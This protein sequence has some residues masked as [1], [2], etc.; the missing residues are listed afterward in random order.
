[1][2]GKGL[3]D[4]TPALRGG[5]SAAP[6]ASGVVARTP[7][8][9][10]ARW[11]PVPA[12]CRGFAAPEISAESVPCTRGRQSERRDA[13]LADQ[14]VRGRSG[15][16]RRDTRRPLRCWPTA[17][18]RAS[19]QAPDCCSRARSRDADRRRRHRPATRQ[20]ARVMGSAAPPPARAQ[21]VEI[22]DTPEIG[23]ELRG[24]LEHGARGTRRHSPRRHGTAG[25]RATCELVTK[26]DRP[27]GRSSRF[28][29][30]AAAGRRERV[31]GTRI[32]PAAGCEQQD[33]E[34]RERRRAGD[35]KRLLLTP[36]RFGG[37]PR[38]CSARRA[39]STVARRQ[40]RFAAL[41]K[42]DVAAISCCSVLM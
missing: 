19:A 31:G 18:R 41:R 21:L 1:M 42:H 36:G 11:R 30:P 16:A 26:G 4:Y 27:A 25:A 39:V 37:V 14:G 15:A 3:T 35:G 12:R 9:W 5:Q 6:V 32:D 20:A 28:G 22:A 13:P 23:A 40:R 34:R 7:A 2:L 17:A 29:E 38:P 8:G 10:A 33:D 24:R